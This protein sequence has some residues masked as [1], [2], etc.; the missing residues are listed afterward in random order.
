MS[1][2]LRER[3][4][5]TVTGIE[6]QSTAAEVAR[7]SADR[8]IVADAEELDYAQ[9]FA[10]ERFDVILFADVLEHLRDP[11]LVLRRV[12]RLLEP[13]GSIVASIP[14]VAHGSVRVA[15][16]GGEFRYTPNGLLD[17][18]HLRFF[19]KDSVLALFEDAR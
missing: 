15:L 11:E 18:T 3:L 4:G 5:C 9:V 12:R 10:S 7:E 2:V 6:V 16:L 14:N 17:D 19:T 8:V 1:A 13:R